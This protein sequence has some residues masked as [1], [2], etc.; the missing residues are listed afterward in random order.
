MPLFDRVRA[1]FASRDGDDETPQ[2]A[3][4][5]AALAAI[6]HG[7]PVLPGAWWSPT[8]RRH[9]CDIPGCLSAALHPAAIAED[10]V[11]PLIPPRNLA[12]YALTTRSAVQERWRRHPYAVLIPTGLAC[13]AIEVPR[14]RIASALE[15]LRQ[16]GDPGPVA[17]SS[18]SA[19][20]FVAPSRGGGEEQLA[21]VSRSRVLAHRAGSWVPLPPSQIEGAAT[22]WLRAPQAVDWHLPEGSATLTA[23]VASLDKA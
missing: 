6:E 9:V 11:S 22:T 15:G 5:A 7:W 12:P 10:P 20:L 16:I 3:L 21:M 4:T 18:T 2:P 14:E 8:L 19:Y 13:D 1:W 23:V 17:L